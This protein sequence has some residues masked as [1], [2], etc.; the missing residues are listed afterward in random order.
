MRSRQAGITFIG[1]I[2]LLAPLAVVAYAAIRLTPVYL[3]YM[4]VVKAIKQTADENKGEAQLNRHAVEVGLQNRFD[5]DGI[6]Y[7]KVSDV[8]VE[9]DGKNWVLSIDYDDEVPMF[10]GISLLVHFDKRAVVE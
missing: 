5:I 7:P 3:N 8:A 10:A 2:F 9:R 6:N 1:W 4:K